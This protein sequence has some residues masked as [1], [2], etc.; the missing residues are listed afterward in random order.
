MLAALMIGALVL[1]LDPILRVAG[2]PAPPGAGRA[3]PSF[4]AAT[5]AGGADGLAEHAGQVVLIDFWA[6]WCPPCVASMPALERLQ[7]KYRDRGLVVL[8]MNQE[9]DDLPSVRAFVAANQLTLPVLIDQGSIARSYGV[10]SYPTS[11]LVDRAGLIRTVHHGPA[12]EAALMAEIEPLLAEAPPAA[13]SAAA[14]GS[15]SR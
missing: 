10:F 1:V 8:G 12:G 5:A 14:T 4:R 11:F 3:A 13:A 9:P 7:R 2:G 6:T 15:E